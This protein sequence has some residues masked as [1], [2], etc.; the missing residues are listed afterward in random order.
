MRCVSAGGTAA[1]SRGESQSL[2]CRHGG[3]L[4]EWS[5]A[6]REVWDSI[7]TPERTATRADTG[8]FRNPRR[9][10]K[11]LPRLQLTRTGTQPRLFDPGTYR[12]TADRD[13]PHEEARR[14]ASGHG[15]TV[16][17]S[18]RSQGSKAIMLVGN[19]SG[20]N[21][22]S[23]NIKGPAEHVRRVRALETIECA[24]RISGNRSLSL[25][26]TDF[27]SSGG[28][29]QPRLAVGNSGDRRSLPQ[30]RQTTRPQCKGVAEPEQ[31]SLIHPTQRGEIDRA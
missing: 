4:R 30:R 15:R 5:V 25:S 29:I 13:G 27:A 20:R 11:G 14:G 28:A 6:L 7:H 17:L 18:P 3:L 16:M 24:S 26:A 22:S 2:G 23:L 8:S 12:T 9:R 21:S 19:G 31:R 1:I 10:S